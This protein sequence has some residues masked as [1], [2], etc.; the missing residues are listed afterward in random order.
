MTTSNLPAPTTAAHGLAIRTEQAFW[1]DKQLAALHQLGVQ[2]ASNGDLAVFLHQVQRT[3]LDPFARQI[4]MIGR[5]SKDGTKWTIQT[6]IDGFRLIGRRAADA[7][8]E[9]L[10]VTD[11]EW[12]GRDGVWR[13]VWLADEPPAAARVAIIRNG[14]RFPAVA[15]FK[16]YV[17]TKR[18]GTPTQMW[19]DK[20]ALMIAKCAEALAWRKA[21]PQDLSGLYTSDEMAQA[22][23]H[24][25][26]ASQAPTP[27]GPPPPP[28]P[29]PMMT[30]DQSAT[31]ARL[32]NANRQSLLDFA[33]ATLARP[34]ENMADIT[35]D[36]AELLI[37]AREQ[38]NLRDTPAAAEIPGETREVAD[39]VV[40]AEFI[41]EATGEVLNEEPRVTNP[42]PYNDDEWLNKGGER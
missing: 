10:E 30:A 26:A 14:G 32:F 19:Q 29:E 39:Q 23:N 3:G 13:D 4:Y 1:D 5:W 31:L 21:F 28:E 34:V 20:G 35:V 40:D 16:E 7:R 17:Q 33:A 9:T 37:A 27:A 41:D 25:P 12:C 24:A 8:R 22:N 36:E 11:T 2:G 18:D 38:M 42:A 6:S 15:L